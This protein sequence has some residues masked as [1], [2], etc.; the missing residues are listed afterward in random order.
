MLWIVSGCSIIAV[1]TV[2]VKWIKMNAGIADVK[3]AARFVTR[4]D[5]KATEAV[6]VVSNFTIGRSKC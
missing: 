2:L 1:V 6:K 4:K 3:F 5:T